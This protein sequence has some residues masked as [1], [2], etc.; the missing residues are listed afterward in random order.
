MKTLTC[1]YCHRKLEHEVPP[2]SEQHPILSSCP[3]CHRSIAVYA[4]STFALT[5]GDRG[6]MAVYPE[7]E[8][9]SKFSF[10]LLPNS[11]SGG[12]TVALTKGK[13]LLGKFNQ[14]SSADLQLP[15]ADPDM[16]RNHLEITVTAGGVTVRDPGSRSGTF[17]NA[18]RLRPSEQ[19]RLSDGDVLTLGGST[20]LF[21]D[22][23]DEEDIDITDFDIE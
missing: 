12:D 1:P 10:T 2:R 5:H 15:S 21:S 6:V 7:E 8:T 13:H 20:L 17:V 22:G 23:S 14:D 9:E 19:R 11:Y 3:Y 16:E 4:T 18:V